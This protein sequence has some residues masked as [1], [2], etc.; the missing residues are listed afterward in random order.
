MSGDADGGVFLV[1]CGGLT[2]LTLLTS[3]YVSSGLFCNGF[4]PFGVDFKDGAWV[5]RVVSLLVC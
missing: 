4:F 5:D 3:W 2:G 1:P